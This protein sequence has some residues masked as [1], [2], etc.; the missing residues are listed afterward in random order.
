[1]LN[2]AGRLV[3]PASTVS[4]PRIL[5]DLPG[6]GANWTYVLSCS[7]DVQYRYLYFSAN[8][9]MMHMKGSLM[10]PSWQ[11]SSEM[12]WTLTTHRLGKERLMQVWL[13]EKNLGRGWASA[14]CNLE[15]MR[16]IVEGTC[17]LCKPSRWDLG[18]IKGSMWWAE[19]F[20]GMASIQKQG[21]ESNLYSLWLEPF[22]RV[23]S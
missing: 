5:L 22:K 20:K 8:K 17:M 2:I 11:D 9:R 15:G 1:M 18:F 7:A 21:L 10:F 14:V 16:Q 3:C 13:K 4:I 23:L 19:A 12:V 6:W